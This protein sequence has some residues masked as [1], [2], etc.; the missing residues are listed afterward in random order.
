MSEFKVLPQMRRLMKEIIEEYGLTAAAVVCEKEY[1]VSPLVHCPYYIVELGDNDVGW[2]H[3]SLRPLKGRNG[4]FSKSENNIVAVA[5]RYEEQRCAG[6]TVL[7]SW[8]G[9]LVPY[10]LLDEDRYLYYINKGY[11]PIQAGVDYVEDKL[12][13]GEG[14]F[15]TFEPDSTLEVR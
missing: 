1:A 2:T 14:F 8:R 4:G 9:H 15:V 10:E 3:I 6:L 11:L 7:P 5:L 12:I 13:K